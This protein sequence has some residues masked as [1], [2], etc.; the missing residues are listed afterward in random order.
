MEKEQLLAAAE[1]LGI[2]V[3]GRWGL[4]RLKV[5][6]V[7]AVTGEPMEIEAPADAS[8]AAMIEVVVMRDVWDEQGNRHNAGSTMTVSVEDAMDG[9]EAG[10]YSRKK[11]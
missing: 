8:G 4:A 9:V 10:T 1:A 7:E 11:G 6:I 3:D 2:E 5:A